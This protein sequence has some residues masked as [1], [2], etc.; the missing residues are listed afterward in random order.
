M[1]FTC[2]TDTE[3]LAWI[4]NE[5]SNILYN[6]LSQAN[7]PA[8]TNFGGIFTV[9][10]LNTTIHGF[11]STATA[12]NVMMN[13]NGANITCTGDVNNPDEGKTQ[14]IIIGYMHNYI[15]IMCWYIMQHEIHTV[16]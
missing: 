2:I 1:V 7:D 4:F 9:K 8:V 12:K 13:Q 15:K 16:T 11:E 5:S 3:H 6:S 14:R 10:L